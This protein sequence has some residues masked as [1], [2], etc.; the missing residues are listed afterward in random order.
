MAKKTVVVE[1]LRELDAALGDLPKAT[2]KSV[3]RRVLKKAGKPIADAAAAKA[4]VLSGNL[5]ISIG[6]ST[7][8]TRRQSRIHRQMFKDDRASVEMF[9]GAGGLAQATQQ[10]FG[11]ERHG[12]QPFMRP[13]WDGNKDR[14][15][16]IIKT[17]LG[18]EIMKAAKRL[19]R[20][21][22]RQA[23]KG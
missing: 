6:V 14:A 9:V 7:K 16:E 1:G 19:A 21:A 20:K 22:A 17:D 3:L 4:P 15:L 10:E 2:G 11:N 18:D 13:A 12:P 23:A 5:Q 8:L